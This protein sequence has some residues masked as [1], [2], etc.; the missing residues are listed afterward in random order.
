MARLQIDEVSNRFGPEHAVRE[1]SA[2]DRWD[3]RA[4]RVPRFGDKPPVPTN[5]GGGLH[6]LSSDPAKQRA[7]RA[8][9]EYLTSEESHVKISQNT[10]Y[11][12][13]RAEGA[14]L[15]ATS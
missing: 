11:R 4:A 10:G 1:A 5:S 6:I 2:K 13:L 8:L 15:L 3:L 7:A 12:P 14:E 9:I